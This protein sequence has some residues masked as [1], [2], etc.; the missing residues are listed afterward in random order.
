[1]ADGARPRVPVIF[2]DVTD[3]LTLEEWE[4]L[5]EWQKALYQEVMRENY[6]HLISLAADFRLLKKEDEDDREN[7]ENLEQLETPLR[8]SEKEYHSLFSIQGVN[9]TGQGSL[10]VGRRNK[11]NQAHLKGKHVE[12]A[13]PQQLS[14]DEKPHKC[15]ECGKSFQKR[16]NLKRHFQTHTG[17]RPYP[18]PECGKSFRQKH[19]PVTHQ[20]THSGV[21]PYNCPQCG[22]SFSSSA[23]F[24]THQSTHRG[25]RAFPCSEGRESF[26]TFR[27]LQVHSRWAGA[28]EV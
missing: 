13:N 14:P 3:Y 15:S 22:R 5:T 21:A 6:N 4:E 9:R 23:R 11:R 8:D 26:Q 18:C 10:A 12:T 17:E 7:A 16:G 1:M 24:K 27:V 20:R 19:H 25:E 28:A 2:E